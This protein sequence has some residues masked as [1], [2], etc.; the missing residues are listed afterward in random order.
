MSQP[1]VNPQAA[2]VPQI[3]QNEELYKELIDQLEDGIY[4]VDR[5]QRIRFW[6]KGAEKITGYRAHEVMGRLCE[7][8]LLM[9]RDYEGT[10]LC[11][12]RCPMAG[13]MRDGRSRSCSVF[14][15]HKQGHSVPV[16]LRARAIQHADGTIVGAV[17]V[18]EEARAPGRDAIRALEPFGCLD[19]SIGVLN[20]GYGEMKIGQRLE[21]WRTFGVPVGWMQAALDHPDD[22]EH[23]F[24]RGV[25][26]AVMKLVGNTLDENIGSFDV[27]T[28]WERTDFRIVVYHCSLEQLGTLGQ[29][30]VLLTRSSSLLWWGDPL[31]VTVS[32]GSTMAEHGDTL[33]TLESRARAACEA[34]HAAGGNQSSVARFGDPGDRRPGLFPAT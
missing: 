1:D 13:V 21:E 24:G 15:R 25:I 16:R 30:L 20:R 26:E 2:V 31:S 22:L 27:L 34:C 8:N 17:E 23:R 32:I 5:E 7:G 11:G 10:L 28:R 4:M 9:H 12:E 3:L 33:D 29:K 6:N 14:L 19:P 18:F